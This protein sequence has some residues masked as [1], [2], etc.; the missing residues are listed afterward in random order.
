M[1]LI[2]RV[3]THGTNH[4]IFLDVIVVCGHTRNKQT[5]VDARNGVVDVEPDTINT[6]SKVD[7]TSGL[8]A[9]MI[10]VIFLLII[11]FFVCVLFAG[12]RII[13]RVV[14]IILSDDV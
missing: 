3:G 1:F 7:V 4:E 12:L 9:R 11:C 13:P 8:R 10:V 5:R 14:L 2:P 6:S